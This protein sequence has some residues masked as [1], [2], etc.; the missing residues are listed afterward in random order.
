MQCEK[1]M[2]CEKIMMR[3]KIMLCEKRGRGGTQKK[4]PCGGFIK[5]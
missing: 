3:K 4:P 1:I 5:I 2:L